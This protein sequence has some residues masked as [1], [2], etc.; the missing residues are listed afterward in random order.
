MKTRTK[1]RAGLIAAGNGI[2]TRRANDTA[3]VAQ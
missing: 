2:N 3:V 1:V